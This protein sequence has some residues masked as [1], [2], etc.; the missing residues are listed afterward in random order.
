MT[1][2]AN[3]PKPRVRRDREFWLVAILFWGAVAPIF[4]YGFSRAFLLP[5]ELLTV[6]L[7]WGPRVGSFVALGFSALGFGFAVYT[8][9]DI[10]KR[11][12]SSLA[13]RA[14]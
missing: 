13:D 9:W 6:W 11:L 14:A 5:A 8:L 2:D 10:W 7:D 3:P 1:H 12:R 4:L